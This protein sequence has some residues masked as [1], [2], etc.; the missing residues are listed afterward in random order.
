LVIYSGVE[1]HTRG[2]SGVMI[3]VHKSISNKIGHYKLWKDR[4]IETILKTQRGHL[5]ILAVYG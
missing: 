5:T 4:V 2:Q 3:W 1:R